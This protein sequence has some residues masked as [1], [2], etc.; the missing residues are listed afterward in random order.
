ML[1][2]VNK[3]IYSV[4]VL[5][6]LTFLYVSA[7]HAFSNNIIYPY[8]SQN[9]IDTH[10]LRPV[11]N[12]FF[13]PLRWFVANGSSFQEESIKVRYGWLR[14]SLI[15]HDK[16]NMRS[17]AVDT[18]EGSIVSNGFTAKPEILA[19]FDAVERGKYVKMIFGVAL[20]KESDSFINRMISIE[21]INLMDD[22]RIQG[23]DFS[24]QES[25]IITDIFNKLKSHKKTCANKYV[26]DYQNKVLKHCLQ[27]GYAENIG[28][29]CYHIV[30]Y[31]VSTSVLKK[32]LDKCDK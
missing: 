28:G 3:F 6:I 32:A 21:V 29:G 23:T 24:K 5:V 16:N 8:E 1:N 13:Y 25:E 7:F 12:T 10:T 30:G 31:S 11:Y 4:G 18:F 2:I 26:E 20:S 14:E 19:A 9:H 22:P 15:K 27:A 17:A